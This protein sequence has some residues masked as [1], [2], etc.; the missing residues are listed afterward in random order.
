[1][2]LFFQYAVKFICGKS[3]GEI[4]APGVY[5]TAINV[6]NP[7]YAPVTFRKKVAIALPGEKP[8][9]VSGFFRARLGP[10]EAF[11][12][13]CADIRKHAESD[14][15]FIKGFVVIESPVEL[16]VV[17]VYTAS[18]ATGQIETLDIE[19]V[20]PRRLE[21]GL[22][23]LIPV[24]DPQPGVGFCRRDEKGNLIVTVLNQGTAGAGPSVTEVDFGAFGVFSLPTPALAA[25]ASVD[26]L[27]PIP[28]GCFRPDC[29]FRITVDANSQVVE[30]NEGNNF[31]S[32]TC[33]G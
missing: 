8:G 3:D 1:M 26:L 4:L 29:S 5:F 20:S 31:A 23:D 11:E 16:D 18:G 19:R 14:E 25:G 17:A 15:R 10:D 28:P 30:S 2:N 9:K 33:L 27:F 21:V 13:D 6:H 24:P 32:G 12:I 7:H 22:P